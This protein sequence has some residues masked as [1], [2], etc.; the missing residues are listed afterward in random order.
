[1]SKEDNAGIYV[2]PPTYL[3]LLFI[4]GYIINK[5]VPISVD[6]LRHTFFKVVGIIFLLLS[7][8]LGYFALKQFFKTNNSPITHKPANSLQTSGIYTISR[9]PMYAG[10]FFF[11]IGVSFY[12][13]NWWHFI[14][15]P[16]LFFIFNNYIIIKEEKY[17]ERK[18]G[19]DYLQYKLKVRRWL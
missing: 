19:K 8:T 5:N 7:M 12:I 13:G 16:L 15:L 4:L 17:L 3:L 10:L 14:L 6:F 1:M 18:F 11:Y 9:N 2:P